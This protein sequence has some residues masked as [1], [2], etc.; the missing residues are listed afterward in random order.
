MFSSLLFYC[1]L[2]LLRMAHSLGILK[3]QKT[4]Q[5]QC[6]QNQVDLQSGKA[7]QELLPNLGKHQC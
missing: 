2:S 3:S 6:I 5:L 1:S 4:N 7:E